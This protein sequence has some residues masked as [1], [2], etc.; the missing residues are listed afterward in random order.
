MTTIWVIW[1]LLSFHLTYCLN[2]F[3]FNSGK[4]SGISLCDSVHAK[5][6][7]HIQLCNSMDFTLPGSFVHRI[8]QARI[9]EWVAI[10]FPRGSSQPRDQICVLYLLY[11]QVGSLPLAPPKINKHEKCA[12][13][14]WLTRKFD[15]GVKMTSF[16]F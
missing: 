15:D 8:L 4:V 11:W 3:F 10:F 9:L 16:I 7:S 13:I 1:F 5:L 6:L 2:F 14:L 12:K